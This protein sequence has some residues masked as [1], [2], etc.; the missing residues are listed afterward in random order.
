MDRVRDGGEDGRRTSTTAL[1]VRRSRPSPT[2]SWTRWVGVARRSLPLL[3]L[4]VPPHEPAQQGADPARGAGFS[5]GGLDLPG[6]RVRTHRG[7]VR[8]VRL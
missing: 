3:R 7:A 5:Y 1:W 2:G 4:P 8:A 6:E